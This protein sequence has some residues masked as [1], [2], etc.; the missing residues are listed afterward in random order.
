MIHKA[1]DIL[2]SYINSAVPDIPSIKSGELANLECQAEYG[3]FIVQ[4]DSFK[5]W[6]LE[7]DS[8]N[9][10]ARIV[11]PNG[12]RRAMGTLFA[13]QERFDI[14]KCHPRLEYGDIVG[15]NRG[16]Y[17]H[18]GIYTGGREVIHYAAK[19]GDFGGDVCIQKTTIDKFTSEGGGFF[20]IDF[21]PEGYE[22]ITIFSPEE[23]VARAKSRLGENKY[24]LVFNNCEHFALWCKTGISDSTQVDNFFG[25]FKQF[26]I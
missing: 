23:T 8:R 18:Y 14:V 16:I 21:P 17:Q 13:M 12:L 20:V 7:F 9:N 2:K 11:D 15:M 25:F 5:G 24:D 3:S 6:K 1:G 22:N 19:K 26:L 4:M 10:L